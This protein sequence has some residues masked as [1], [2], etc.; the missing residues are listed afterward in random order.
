M[1]GI[2][3]DKFFYNRSE[4]CIMKVHEIIVYGCIIASCL[5]FCSFVL[6]KVGWRSGVYTKTILNEHTTYEKQSQSQ[7]QLQIESATEE[8]VEY[9]K[10]NKK[11]AR[12]R[13]ACDMI[14]LLSILGYA[15]YLLQR[16]YK[17]EISDELRRFFP[18]ETMVLHSAMSMHKKLFEILSHWTIQDYFPWN[19]HYHGNYRPIMDEL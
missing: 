8:D 10:W 16:E 1:P 19:L 17:V 4:L 3:D 14:V 13:L 7:A 9:E 12:A 18:K 5:V 2:S 15:A 6:S 11:K